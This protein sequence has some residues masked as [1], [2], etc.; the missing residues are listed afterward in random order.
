MK[1]IKYTDK[2]I[3]S[4]IYYPIKLVELYLTSTIILYVFGPWT[5]PTHNPILFYSFMIL[6]Q[7]FLWCGYSRSMD[8]GININVN[9]RAEIK[10]LKL[11]KYGIVLNL[12]FIILNTIRNT[13]MNAFSIGL[14]LEKA[15]NGILNP[16]Q[17]YQQ[18]FNSITFGGSI[19]THLTV[20][21]SP[22]LW[23]IIPF[24]L[25]YFK[26]L[27]FFNRIVT[28]ISI[29]FE[30]IRWIATGTNKG[31]FDL[32]II[33]ITIF[34]I[35]KKQQLFAEVSKNQQVRKKKIFVII[36]L[37]ITIAIVF[38]SNAIDSRVKGNWNNLIITNGGVQIDFDSLLMKICPKFLESTL[39]YLTSYLTQGYYALSMAISLVF[40]PMFGIGNSMFLMENMGQIFNLDFFQFTYQTKLVEY[41]WKSLVNWHSFYVWVA[42]DVHFI[43]VILIMYILGYYFASVYK[44]AIFNKNPIAIAIICLLVLLFVYIPANNQILSYPTTFMAF[45][46]L[47]IYWLLKKYRIKIR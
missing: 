21:L 39:I 32:I 16:A 47:T 45:W 12:V 41:G 37:S 24:S 17:Q 36:I 38:F 23:P 10:L 40:T 34:I 18:K 2:N 7:L 20:I 1:R 46:G 8:R 3:R 15:T 30:S 29:L 27:S 5:W 19:L 13:G 9:S 22:I 42:N 25:F 43:G 28:V 11:L 14:L 4:I 6:A 35:K 44:D 33:F 26:K 31:I